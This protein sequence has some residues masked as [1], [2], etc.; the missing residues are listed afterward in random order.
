L[1]NCIVLIGLPGSGKTE[2]AEVLATKLGW[3]WQDTDREIESKTG[4]SIP[5]IFEQS[6]ESTF[7]AMET[8][9]VAGMVSSNIARCVVSTGGGLPATPGNFDRL[10]QLGRIIYLSLP[11]E[12]LAERVGDGSG[13]PLLTGQ[14]NKN[15]QDLF[16]QRHPIYA[17]ADITLDAAD[18]SPDQAAEAIIKLLGMSK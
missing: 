13:R 7:R 15:L 18:M 11:L 16:N 8:E 6:G 10:R 3:N 17:Q 4:K 9:I 2:C 1:I 12:T 5:E 14:V